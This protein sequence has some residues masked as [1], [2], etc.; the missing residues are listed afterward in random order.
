M[1]HIDE[2]LRAADQLGGDVAAAFAPVVEHRRRA[3]TLNVELEV[4]RRDGEAEYGRL[5]RALST[6][7]VKPDEL[8]PLLASASTWAHDSLAARAVV[9]AAAGARHLADQATRQ[10]APAAFKAL[11]RLVSGVVA[12][13][14]DLAG[15]LPATVTSESLVLRSGD[16]NAAKHW[17]RLRVLVDLWDRGHAA[18]WL[19]QVRCRLLGPVEEYDAGVVD[20]GPYLKFGHPEKLPAGY[21]GVLAP[22]LK[23]ARAYAAGAEP[24]LVQI[25]AA[26]ARARRAG[27]ASGRMRAVPAMSVVERIDSLG[28]VTREPAPAQLVTEQQ[29]ARAV[30]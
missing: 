12:E 20:A 24:G 22:E 21:H 15:R 14:V 17:M 29:A 16:E 26:A 5:V 7:E 8:P 25:T 23:L 4:R 10:A 11:Q 28:N 1:T 3:D 18:A 2:L 6:G 27:V 9:Q 30:S 19:L 13:S